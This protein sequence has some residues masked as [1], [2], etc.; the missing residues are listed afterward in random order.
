MRLL[1][2]DADA[3]KNSSFNCLVECTIERV[4]TSCGWYWFWL[5]VESWRVH[6]YISYLRA[7]FSVPCTGD[8]FLVPAGREWF[9]SCVLLVTYH[10]LCVVSLQRLGEKC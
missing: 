1:G 5:E 9:R 4:D 6:C 7:M 8:L 3:V 10:I 2:M